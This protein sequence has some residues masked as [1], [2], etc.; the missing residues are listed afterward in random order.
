M[1]YKIIGYCSDCTNCDPMGCNDGEPFDLGEEQNLD[2]ARKVAKHHAEG[3]G[4][5]YS[6]IVDTNGQ[7]I[8]TVY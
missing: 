5:W 6:E 2:E 3:A 7:I 1:M 8:E 4:P